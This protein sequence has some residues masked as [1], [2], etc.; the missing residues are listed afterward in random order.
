MGSSTKDDDFP[1]LQRPLAAQ[2]HE[3][4]FGTFPPAVP[5]P[6]FMS[7]AAVAGCDIIQKT[8]RNGRSFEVHNVGMPEN[9]GCMLGVRKAAI[10]LPAGSFLVWTVMVN[11]EPV[12]VIDNKLNKLN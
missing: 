4:L 12:L 7:A 3:T 2:Y 9:E 1:F 8:W 11:Q 5:S 10:Q 6:S